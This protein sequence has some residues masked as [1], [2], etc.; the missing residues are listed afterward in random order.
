MLNRIRTI[1]KRWLVVTAAAALM[2]VGL[3][4]GAVF[5]AGSPQR[6]FDGNTSQ[7]M[8]TYPASGTHHASQEQFIARV[9]EILGIEPETV[10][11]AFAT[12]QH[13][14]AT[15]HFDARIAT[16]VENGDL[17]EEQGEA[18][19]AWFAARPADAGF[20]AFFAAATAD[21]DRLTKILD[22][23]VANE[24]LTRTR[25]TPSSTGTPIA[26]NPCP[27]TT[28]E[29][30]ANVDATGTA[31]IGTTT[32]GTTTIGTTTIGT[33][34]IGTTTIGTT[35]MGTTPMGTTPRSVGCS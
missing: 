1:R 13:E 15:E 33:T 25:P 4:A 9:A 30:S 8:K 26:P 23:A 10:S 5:A 29:C 17:T 35:T 28:A 14:L 2:A 18:A 27:N 7:A 24:R 34:T 32:I 16:L 12:A 6:H 31:T 21:T 3:T 22:H 20:I 19:S 11:N